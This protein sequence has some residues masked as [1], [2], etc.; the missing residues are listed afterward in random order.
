MVGKT[1]QMH[2]QREL[3]PLASKMTYA[4]PIKINCIRLGIRTGPLKLSELDCA[5]GNGL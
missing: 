4:K 3:L 2:H 1:I 5:M